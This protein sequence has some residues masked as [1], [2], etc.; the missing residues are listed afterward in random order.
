LIKE[1]GAVP[2]KSGKE[3]GGGTGKTR[4]IYTVLNRE[5]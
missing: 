3:R 1:A 5:G 2:P 4:K